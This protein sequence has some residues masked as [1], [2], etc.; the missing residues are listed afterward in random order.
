MLETTLEIAYLFVCY[1]PIVYNFAIFNLLLVYTF[2]HSV[3]I[4]CRYLYL[5]SLSLLPLCRY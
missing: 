2:V 3:S 5:R 1:P 4:M